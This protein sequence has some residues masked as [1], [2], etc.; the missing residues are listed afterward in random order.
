MSQLTLMPEIVLE[1]STEK[2]ILR[3]DIL[4]S[5]SWLRPLVNLFKKILSPSNTKS[6]YEGRR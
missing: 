1:A 4:L 5:A 2:D 3:A 6:S